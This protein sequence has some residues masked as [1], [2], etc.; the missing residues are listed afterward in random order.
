MKSSE[1]FCKNF[2][3]LLRLNLY[4]VQSTRMQLERAEDNSALSLFRGYIL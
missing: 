2:H 4:F 1:E 3:R